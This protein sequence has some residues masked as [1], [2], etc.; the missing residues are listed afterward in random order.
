M[1]KTIQFRNMSVTT[2]NLMLKQ[3]SKV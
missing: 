3:Q 2:R 1:K